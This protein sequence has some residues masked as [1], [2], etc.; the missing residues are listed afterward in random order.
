[1]LL[2]K[3]LSMNDTTRLSMLSLPQEASVFDLEALYAGRANHSRS[4]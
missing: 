1:M 3:G 4:S 2:M